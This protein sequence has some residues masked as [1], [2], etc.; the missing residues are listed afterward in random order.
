V[1]DAI[2]IDAELDAE[3]GLPLSRWYGY[4]QAH[5]GYGR[6]ENHGTV[7][8]LFDQDAAMRY[9]G[10]TTGWAEDRWQAHCG[11]AGTSDIVASWVA[12]LRAIGRLP[13][14]RILERCAIDERLRRESWWI[15]WAMDRGCQLLNWQAQQR[16]PMKRN[17][18]VCW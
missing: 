7:Y 3:A 6:F 14:V 11:V 18:V 9:V 12:G 13:T 2:R 4:L 5:P 1:R 15:A 16:K 17:K 10:Q 8:A